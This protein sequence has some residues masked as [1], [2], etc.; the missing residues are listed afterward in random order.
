[1]LVSNLF[2]KRVTNNKIPGAAIA[3]TVGLVLA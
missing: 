1:M 3:I 2:A